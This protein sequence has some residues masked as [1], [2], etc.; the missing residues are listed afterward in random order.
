MTRLP[1]QAAREGCTEDC[2]NRHSFIHCDPK[3][4]PC[5]AVCSNRPFHALRPPPMEVRFMA[6]HYSH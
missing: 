6:S 1:L 2:L 4:C 5:G 3:S